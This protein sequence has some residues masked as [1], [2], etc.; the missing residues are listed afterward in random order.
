MHASCSNHD[1]RRKEIRRNSVQDQSL[2]HNDFPREPVTAFEPL[3]SRA[4]TL[5]PNQARAGGVVGVPSNCGAPPIFYGGIQRTG[6]PL[7]SASLMQ[8]TFSYLEVAGAAL[9]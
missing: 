9:F 7:N 1:V 5:S 2:R 6:E 3:S 4:R 8:G